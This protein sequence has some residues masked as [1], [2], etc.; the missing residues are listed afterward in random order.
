MPAH[1]DR[2]AEGAG[3]TD[4]TTAGRDKRQIRSRQVLG[5]QRQAQ[6]LPA[7]R[8]E[9]QRHTTVTTATPVDATH[10]CECSSEPPQVVCVPCLHDRRG[11]LV[12]VCLERLYVARTLLQCTMQRQYA[13]LCDTAFM[14]CSVH[15]SA[16][17]NAEHCCGK[18]SMQSCSA[19]LSCIIA[20]CSIPAVRIIT[21]H[22]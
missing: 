16:V 22:A 3:Y 5:T 2:S 20:I 10:C 9:T 18:A 14:Q 13:K 17:H 15:T 12:L 19:Q 8:T 1:P 7:M 11:W 6:H 21:K 4:R